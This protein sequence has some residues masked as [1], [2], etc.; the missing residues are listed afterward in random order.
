MKINEF[1]DEHNDESKPNL[2]F[3]VVSDLHVHMKNDPMFYRKQ[4]YPTIAN[5]QD[6]LK[7]GNPIDTKKAMLPMVNKGINHY[8]A[9]YSIP[10][11]PEDLMQSEEIDAL[12]EKIYGEEMELIEKGDY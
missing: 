12:I 9:K 10:K 1:I 4:Y 3:D 8:C 5:M 2:G 11:R 7:Q 6:R